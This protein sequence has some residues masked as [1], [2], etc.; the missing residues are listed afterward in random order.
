MN[1]GTITNTSLMPDT[2][3][4]NGRVQSGSASQV[5][6]YTKSFQQALH[7]QEQSLAKPA[8]GMASTE[9]LMEQLVGIKKD[10]YDKIVHGD[11]TQ[12]FAI[13]NQEFSVQEWDKLM[14]D[15][16]EAEEALREAVKEELEV[17]LEEQ[18]KEEVLKA[19]NGTT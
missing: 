7:Q 4:E 18:E 2:R 3:K 17:R 11:T 12:K 9:E 6:A 19:E 1:I 16:D 13:G 15:F 5:T 10:I 14:A 8:P